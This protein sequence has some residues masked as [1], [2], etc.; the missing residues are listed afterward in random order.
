MNIKKFGK[1]ILATALSVMTAATMLCVGV[2]ANAAQTRY[3]VDTTKKASLTI[4]KYEMADTS[5]ATHKPTGTAQDAQYVPKDAK[6]LGG[7]TFTIYQLSG[8]DNYFTPEGVELPKAK[9]VDKSTAIKSYS[10]TTGS[11]GVAKFTDLPLGI[12]YVEETDGPAQITKK[13]APFVLSLPMTDVS[14]KQWLYNVETYPK[15]QTAYGGLTLEKID[16]KTKEPLKGAEFTLYSST[17]GETYKEYKT[18]IVTGANGTATISALPSNTYYKFVETKAS[19]DSYILDST[20]GYEFFVDGTG[21]VLVDNK[22]VE[23]RTITVGNDTI[24]IHKYVLDGA[25][26]AEGIDNTVNYGDTVHWKIKTTIPANVEKLKTYTI[27]DTM[28]TGLEY[29]ASELWID[30]K[31]QLIKDTD[32]TVSQDG[33]NVT[34][35]IAPDKL[36]GGSEVEVYFDTLLT[37]E[38][39]LA[40]DIPNTSKIVYTNKIN[41]DNTYTKNSETPNV[42]TGGYSFVKTDGDKPLQGAQFAIYA[43]ETDAKSGTNPILTATSDKNGLVQFKGLKYGSFS[44][45]EAGKNKNGTA[46]GS[47]EYWLA[48]TAAPKGYILL[49]APFKVSVNSKSHIAAN[50][51]D[52]IN[53]LLPELPITGAV[54]TVA[55]FTLSGVLIASGVILLTTRRRKKNNG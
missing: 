4:H 38:A 27:V 53:D 32:Y 10:A 13:I 18:G 45:D 49:S 55:L 37:T 46:N 54:G 43:T 41:T 29:S 2:T 30:D 14:G 9:D 33:L 3:L 15:N 17:D 21:D 50:N 8:L 24:D 42:H 7:V 39:P 40:T 52:I 47:T 22:V 31:T 44:S 5:L 19:D 48:E 16:S 26:G 36:S 51:T 12:Y 34:F 28:S 35:T 6:P 20:V 23:N 11:D 1:R 25:K